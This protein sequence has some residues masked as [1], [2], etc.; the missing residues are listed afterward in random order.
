MSKNVLECQCL[1]FRRF[2]TAGW[3]LC[4]NLLAHDIFLKI[5]LISTFT[6]ILPAKNTAMQSLYVSNVYF[7][8]LLIIDVVITHIQTSKRTFILK[9]NSPLMNLNGL[10]K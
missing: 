1:K 10:E 4:F 7:T 3:L 5:T 9:T 8:A 6:F 2:L